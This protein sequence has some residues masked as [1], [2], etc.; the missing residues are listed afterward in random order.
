MNRIFYALLITVLV[1]FAWIKREAL[2][3][4]FANV[5]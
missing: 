5:G 2:K 4:V 3:Q 1:Y